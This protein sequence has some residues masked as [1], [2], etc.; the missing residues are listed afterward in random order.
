MDSFFAEAVVW[1]PMLRREGPRYTTGPTQSAAWI[2]DPD[3]PVRGEDQINDPFS[4]VVIWNP[5][6]IDPGTKAVE[7]NNA[8]SNSV[9]LDINATLFRNRSTGLLDYPRVNDRFEVPHPSG[10]RY[11]VQMSRPPH[12]DGTGR[13]QLLCIA[14][15]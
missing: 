11:P 10:R 8:T 2:A 14:T 4:A 6:T 3:R 7:T 15:D 13:I 9:M 12:D 5:Q 1:R